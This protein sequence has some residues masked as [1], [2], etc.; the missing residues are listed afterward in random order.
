[1]PAGRRHCILTPPENLTGLCTGSCRRSNQTEH[2]HPRTG[3]WCWRECPPSPCASSR[4]LCWIDLSSWNKPR[5]QLHC[6]LGCLR[7]TRW[8][9][10]SGCPSCWIQAQLHCKE[11]TIHPHSQVLYNC[12]RVQGGQGE[13]QVHLVTAAEQKQSLQ[14]VQDAR[15]SSSSREDSGLQIEKSFQFNK[16]KILWKLHYV[17]GAFALLTQIISISIKAW[18]LVGYLPDT[19]IGLGSILI[20][21]Q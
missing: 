14:F 13:G 7:Q 4:Y 6:C 3:G 8:C 9:R 17:V 2:R 20:L 5:R 15:R 12:L 18:S 19:V 16:K 11:K 21:Y 1:M 10:W